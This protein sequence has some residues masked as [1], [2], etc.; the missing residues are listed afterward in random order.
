MHGEKVL[1]MV[2]GD[3]EWVLVDLVAMGKLKIIVYN[4]KIRNI[5]NKMLFFET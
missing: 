2:D 4:N 1:D 5:R 3:M